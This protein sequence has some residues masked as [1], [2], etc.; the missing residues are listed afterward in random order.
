MDNANVRQPSMR[1]PLIG[2]VPWWI[3]LLEGIASLILGLF[4]ITMP[5]IT[6]LAAVSFLGA[7]WF[8]LGLLAIYS[9]FTD[10]THLG[11]KL[12]AGILGI[13]AGLA[14]LLYP[15]IS[16]IAVPLAFILYIAILGVILGFI[17]LYRAAGTGLWEYAVT[18]IISILFGL[19]IIINPLA[20]VIALPY[21]LGAISIAGGIVA[22]AAALSLRSAKRRLRTAPEGRAVPSVGADTAAARVMSGS[23]APPASNGAD[24]ADP[25]GSSEPS[26]EEGSKM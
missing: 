20:A 2:I 13:I 26:G 5:A 17:S 23:T 4:F 8:F 18:G 6:L 1:Q 22:I 3:V 12:A 7:Y 11:R 25:L 14:V 10:R 15:M 19:I 21:I 24:P 16:T 9:V